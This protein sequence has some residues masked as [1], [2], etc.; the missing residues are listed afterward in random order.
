MDMFKLT[1]WLSCWNLIPDGTP[2]VTHTSQL[3]PVKTATHGIKAMLKVTDDPDE[4]AGNALMVWWEGNGAA[5]VIA[6]EKEAILLSRATGSASLSAMSRGDRD[7]IACRILCM[8]ANRLHSFAKRPFPR[9][10]SLREWFYPLKPAALQ[11]GGILTRCA[12]ISEELLSS[13]RDVVVLHGDLHHGNVLDFETSGWLAIDPKG[14][15]G[16]RGFDFA[17]IFTNPDLGYPVPA[18]ATVPETFKQ[19]LSIVTRMADMDKERLL[20]WIIAWCGLSTAWS[21]SS[22]ETTS[23][24]IKIAELAIAELES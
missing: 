9:L 15:I 4:Q 6:H 20:K 5:H 14:L 11:Y 7:D 1:P 2:F 19:R 18:V 21:L 3:Y 10:T 24:T 22:N 16:E 12:E 17:N 13:P 8:T 23:I